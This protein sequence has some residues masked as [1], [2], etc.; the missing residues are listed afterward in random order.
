MKIKLFI[1]AFMGMVLVAAGQ[2]HYASGSVLSSGEWVKLGISKQGI[3]KV[4]GEMLLKAGF[5]AE[6]PSAGIHLFGNGGKM[7]PEGN[8][9]FVQ[10]DLVENA[11]WIEDGGDGKFDSQDWFLFYGQGPN[12][13]E[14]DS[15]MQTHHFLHNPYSTQ[16]YFFVTINNIPGKRISVQAPPI[17]SGLLVQSYDE[18]IHHE[19][20]SVNLLKSGREWYGEAFDQQ[21]G[22]IDRTFNFPFSGVI[23]GK[24][25]SI[26]SEVIGRSSGQVNH[27]LVQLN[28]AKIL[29]HT[30]QTLIGTLTEPAANVSNLS[31]SLNSDGGAIE[32]KYS[33]NPGSINAK[34]WI[35]W[36]ELK[37]RH[38]LTLNTNGALNFRDIQSAGKGNVVT[39]QIGNTSA[40]TLV[41]DVTN[42][43]APELIKTS[44]SGSNL[45]FSAHADQLHEYRAFN[46]TSIE[47]P[48]MIAH[49]SNQNL[50]GL[51]SVQMVII[52]EKLL[53]NEA[54]RLAD[55][56][57][58]HDRMTVAVT[59]VDQIYN[60]FSSG[61]ADPTAIRNFL[62]M[63]YDRS[64]V[65]GSDRLQYALFFGGASYVYK[66]TTADQY[67]HVPSYESASSLDPLTSYVT[68]DYFGFLD[69]NDDI[70][71]TN[72]TL[73]LDISI[74]RIPVRNVD[75]ARI[76]VNKIIAYHAPTALGNWRNKISFVADD[77]DYNVHLND[78][79][80]HTR[81]VESLSPQINIKK[82]YLDAFQ[83]ESGSGGSRYPLVNKAI[84]QTIEEGT[85]ILNYSGHGGSIRLAQEA[86][87]DKAMTAAWNNSQRLPLF[88]TATCDF[89]PF[90]DH[91]QFSIGEDLLV[92]RNTGAIGLLTTTRLVFASS[93]KIINNNYLKFLLQR[94]IQGHYTSTGNALAASKNFTVSTSGDFINTRKFILL[95]DPAMK[96]AIPEMKI[97]T[98]AINGK[99]LGMDT[100]KGGGKY[101]FTGEV[102]STSGSLASD[103]NGTLYP[104]LYARPSE[105][106][107]LVNDPQSRP[108]TFE[109]LKNILYTGKVSVLQGRF[110]FSIILPIDMD[111]SIAFG[112]LSYYAE[113][114]VVDA[115]GVEL[116]L[117][118]GGKASVFSTDKDGPSLKCYLNTTSFTNGSVVT[119]IST[120]YVSLFDSSGINISGLGIGHD[121]TAALDGDYRKTWMLNEYFEPS[122][123]SIGG[124]NLKFNIPEMEEGSHQLIVRAWDN[125]NNSSKCTM[126]FKVVPI[127]ETRIESLKLYPNP[128]SMGSAVS[129]ALSGLSGAVD[130]ELQIL[131]IE[132]ICVKTIQ[133]AINVTA[134]RSIEVSWD[135]L[136]E[137]GK[138]PPRGNYFFRL[139]VRNETG[140]IVHKVQKLI[141]R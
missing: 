24:P 58:T 25:I 23:P 3:Y 9:Q 119:P 95:G 26:N 113:N 91:T 33:F 83:Q 17:T 47:K 134:G 12:V 6:M 20:D 111:P 18:F 65:S 140:R 52:T 42:E 35:N 70:S 49:V 36:F 27:I 66:G 106:K 37:F 102:Q 61:S 1:V 74:G 121:I 137:M 16:S 92:G 57:R 130:I 63:L 46:P 98:T 118:M 96:I 2:R 31:T 41:W 84:D 131:T 116:G 103:F 28:G 86:I 114:A 73:L 126:E 80:D 141:L 115:S 10:D 107:T 71:K 79:E 44:I 72:N 75:Q 94:N 22:K 78:A 21:T 135:G 123:D 60:E 62:K 87:L 5:K 59:E 19:L 85:L 120:L 110:N 108:S 34:A 69:D 7:L 133:K 127:L 82:I 30:T 32:L 11:I 139:S 54:N 104:T 124:G 43:I 29:D 8:I 122:K 51:T 117:T 40:S 45:G 15:I 109:E 100:L 4:T 93:N 56:H 76:A 136:D 77:E 50:H 39:F 138:K 48:E 88:I 68:D 128:S 14:Y 105:T 132:G 129:F 55:F 81:L 89:A 38:V 13:W 53:L 101:F 125:F 97:V 90:D 99:P 64:N 112:K 67:N